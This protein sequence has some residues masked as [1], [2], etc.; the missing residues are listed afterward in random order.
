MIILYLCIGIVFFILIPTFCYYLIQR[1]LTYLMTTNNMA[2]INFLK[3]LYFFDKHRLVLNIYMLLSLIIGIYEALRIFLFSG[4]YFWYAILSFGLYIVLFIIPIGSIL[5]INQNKINPNPKMI[6]VF[7]FVGWITL[8]WAFALL[9]YS[10]PF[11]YTD[12]GGIGKEEISMIFKNIA[13]LGLLGNGFI[14]MIYLAKYNNIIAQIE[15]GRTDDERQKFSTSIKNKLSNIFISFKPFFCLAVSPLLLTLITLVAAK[16]MDVGLELFLYLTI[17]AVWLAVISCLLLLQ[18]I[19]INKLYKI[20]SYTIYTI[21]MIIFLIGSWTILNE[22]TQS[23]KFFNEIAGGYLWYNYARLIL[24]WY[25]FIAGVM[26]WG[27]SV[28]LSLKN[29]TRNSLDKYS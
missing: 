23:F 5:L 14:Q 9:F 11:V 12:E 28:V 20:I 3:C 24:S 22:F 4:A 26:S 25:L 17:E 10:H 27:L 15:R 21:G 18:K 29:Q 8:F 1:G 2:K 16:I 7:H 19:K 13:G 6:S